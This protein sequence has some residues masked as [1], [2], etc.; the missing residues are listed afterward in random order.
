TAANSTNIA[1]LPSH[2]VTLSSPVT[3]DDCVVQS[4]GQVTVS[5]ATL[6]LSGTG[7]DVSGVLKVADSTSS[8]ISGDSLTTLKFENGG[9]YS[10]LLHTA[11]AIPTATWAANSTCEIAP[12]A[13]GAA[14]PSNL[15]Q[16]FGNFNWNWPSQNN[17]V[18]LGGALTNVARDLTI[19]SGSIVRIFNA[20]GGNISDLVNVETVGGNFTINGGTV[21]TFGT[22]NNNAN[23][24][25]YVGGNFTIAPGATLNCP[26]TGTN[27]T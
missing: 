13:A 10:S 18:N 11:T 5:G 22:A 26:T 8:L 4:G 19:S 3:V 20:G 2:T 1:I 12:T 9:K 17:T 21:Y 15:G 6:T 25:L 24:T 27:S 23:N 14:V 16:A 7:L